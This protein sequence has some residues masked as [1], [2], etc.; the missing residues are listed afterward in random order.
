[1]MLGGKEIQN[2]II[3]RQVPA[4]S[5]PLRKSLTPSPNPHQLTSSGAHAA[6]LDLA[7]LNTCERLWLQTWVL[8]TRERLWLQTW[9][10]NN[11]RRCVQNEGLV[12]VE[13]ASTALDQVDPGG[14]EQ[15]TEHRLE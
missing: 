10:L 4:K 13:S 11:C 9:V 7:V 15:Q 14:S 5:T 8:N 6:V 12:V 2:T 1:M 3:T